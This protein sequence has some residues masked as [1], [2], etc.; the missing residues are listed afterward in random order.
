MFL[1]DLT[2]IDGISTVQQVITGYYHC[3]LYVWHSTGYVDC[4]SLNTGIQVPVS[5]VGQRMFLLDLNCIDG[6][7]IVQQVIITVNWTRYLQHVM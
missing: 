2:C 5:S 6:I 7:Q 4:T 1:L 3:K